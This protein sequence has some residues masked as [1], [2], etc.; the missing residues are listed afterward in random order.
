M[1]TVTNVCRLRSYQRLNNKISRI[2]IK[3]FEK[4]YT[5]LLYIKY[6]QFVFSILENQRDQAD[7]DMIINPIKPI[8]KL[9]ALK[10]LQD[11]FNNICVQ[12]WRLKYGETNIVAIKNRIA[13]EERNI[14]RHFSRYVPEL[15][16]FYPFQQN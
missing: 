14:A 9:F 7:R 6:R 10:I 3:E 2:I 11:A 1:V 12:F 13:I 5:F 16:W 4:S 8:T 15:N